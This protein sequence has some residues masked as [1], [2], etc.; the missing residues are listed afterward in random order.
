MKTQLM[1]YP[2]E[3][4]FIDESE[5]DRE[6]TSQLMRFCMSVILQDTSKMTL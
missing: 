1:S 4:E 6:L 3:D 2:P 5:Q